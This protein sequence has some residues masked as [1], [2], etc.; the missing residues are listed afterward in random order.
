MAGM[1]RKLAVLGAAAEAARRFAR[2][3]PEKARD[4]TNKAAAFADKQTKGK[5]RGQIES[6]KRS[7]ANAGGFGGDT[8][9]HNY[10]TQPYQQQP[11]PYEPKPY[12]PEH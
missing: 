12:K 8:G 7:V 1:F 5:Y 11:K 2:N 3:N 10:G 4:L 9:G 6:V